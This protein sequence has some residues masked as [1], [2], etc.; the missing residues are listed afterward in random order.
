[1]GSERGTTWPSHCCWVITYLVSFKTQLISCLLP[2]RMCQPLFHN[3]RWLMASACL[4]FI[5]F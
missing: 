4:L 3:L 5:S 1:M 2:C